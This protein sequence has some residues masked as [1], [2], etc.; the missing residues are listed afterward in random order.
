MTIVENLQRA[1]LNPM[2]QARAFQRLSRDFHM[3]QEQMAT[4]TGKDR[5]SVSNFLRLLLFTAGV[6][7]AA[8]GKR[9]AEL[10]PRA[11]AAGAWK[12]CHAVDG[13]RRKRC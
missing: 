6:R 10:R 11:R 12:T 9:C 1:D 4:R 8:C 2:E 7:P 5:A 13:R 3:T